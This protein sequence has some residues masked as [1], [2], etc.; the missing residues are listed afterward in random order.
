MSNV[1]L[2]RKEKEMRDWRRVAETAL[3]LIIVS[4][5][6]FP[7]VGQNQFV[8]G[9]TYTI[10]GPPAPAGE[11]YTYNWAITA[12][13]P[14]TSTEASFKWTSPQ[15]TEPTK[16]IVN[17]TVESNKTICTG[18]GELEMMILPNGQPK[19]S[20]KKDCIFNAPVRVDD[21]ITYTYNVTNSGG[22][23]LTSINL[24]DMQDWGPDCRPVYVKGD[25]GDGILNP[26]ET[27]WYE[28]KYTVPDPSD[29]QQLYI[30]SNGSSKE[31]IIQKLTDMKVRLEMKMESLKSRQRQFNTVS[32]TLKIDH[33]LLNGTNYILY[34][35]TNEI[36]GESFSR[37]LDSEGRISRSDYYDPVNQAVLTEEYNSDGSPK[38]D[39]IHLLETNEYMKIEYDVPTKGYRS[40]TAIDYI[41]GDTLLLLIDNF[42]N[43]VSKEYRKTPGYRP[44][45][46]KFFLKNT[47]SVTAKAPDGSSVSDMDSFSLEIYKK[48]PILRITK[49]ANPD[50]VNPGG[51]INYTITYEN[52]GKDDAHQIVVKEKY[53]QNLIFKFA[54]PIPDAGTKD[55]WTLGDL[56]SGESGIIRIAANVSQTATAGSTIMNMATITCKENATDRTTINTTVQG[57]GLNITKSAS[58]CVRAGD[59]LTYTIN[60]R[61][62]GLGTQNNVIIHDYLDD[63][64]VSTNIQPAA[65]AHL[66]NHYW[67]RVGDL[68]AGDSGKIT[69]KVHVNKNGEKS[70]YNN[71]KIDSDQTKGSNATLETLVV[72]SLWIRKTADKKAYCPGENVTYTILYGN[73]E[74]IPAYGVNVTDVLPN[75]QLLSVSPSPTSING[76]SLIWKIGDLEPDNQTQFKKPNSIQIVVHIPE[77]PEMKFDEQSSVRGEGY[78]YVN[79]KLSTVEENTALVNIAYI[80]GTYLGLAD[81]EN[82]SSA[83]TVTILGAAGTELSTYEHGSGYYK[84]DVQT[85]LRSKNHSISL[86]KD[87][88]AQHNYTDFSLPGGRSISYKSLWYDRTG[89]KNHVL[90]DVVSENYLYMDSLDKESSFHVDENQTVYHSESDFSGGIAVINYK[91]Q[92]PNSTITTQEISENYHGS[93]RVL[94]SVDSYGDSTKY[95]KSST[96]S[97]FASS[98]KRVNQPP[99]S[100]WKIPEVLQRSYEYGSGYYNSEESSQLST[101]TKSTK[102]AYAPV[103][104]TFGTINVSY[105]SPWNEGL[106]TKDTSTGL[107]LSEDIRSASYINKDAWMTTSTLS[108]MGEFN[109]SMDIMALMHPQRFETDR[110]DQTLIGKYT[111]NTAI[112]GYNVIGYF[113]P[114]VNI[115]KEAIRV[116]ENTMLFLINVTNDGNGLLR[117]LNV[118]DRLPDG[119]IFINSSLRPDINGQ[120]VN[121]TIPTLDIGKTLTI[122]LMTNIENDRY[123]YR[124]AVEVTAQ[125]N[126]HILTASNSTYSTPYY[127]PYGFIPAPQKVANLS[128]VYNNSTVHGHWGDW[129]PPACYNMTSKAPNCFKEIDEYYN[130]LDKMDSDG[131]SPYEVP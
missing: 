49:T 58:C 69:I 119:M 105:A 87:I 99:Q 41:T 109:G 76:R 25:N 57:A 29:Y 108:F 66:G 47:A 53:D 79:K 27:W 44:Y 7:V 131:C 9:K 15:V 46:E 14:Q 12:G 11:I 6:I 94:E 45:E 65:T 115:C 23:P 18:K 129:N 24:T 50:P 2:A 110:I 122:K 3:I 70:I 127:P 72:E 116:D 100:P 123:P 102:M 8:S 4:Q 39:A 117:S 32:A 85:S 16:V 1:S 55:T 86:N 77:R 73:S 62:D 43:I 83:S 98:D 64:V 90:N 97:G 20:L 35:Y 52:L 96:G 75:V 125:Y 114:H 60:Y 128:K 107:K 38:S 31:V 56:K 126:G 30:M 82:K 36:T 28:C 120:F 19:I 112:T 61:N 26:K 34:N 71:Y 48:L 106:S 63:N 93:F 17:L 33:K 40:Y 91:K 121:W 130:D 104:L 95:E 21:S 113:Y 111:I 13:T 74:S 5:T 81:G 124:N 54:Y 118:T 78:V 80:N 22:V 68:N 84:E 89:A 10:S 88:T 37:W 42:G 103:N 101:V 59:S 51:A 67:W 92:V